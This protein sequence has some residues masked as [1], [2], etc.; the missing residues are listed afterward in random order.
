MT[1]PR[2]AGLPNGPVKAARAAL[3][4]A[5]KALSDDQA[6]ASA[7]ALVGI[8]FALVAIAEAIAPQSMGEAGGQES[9]NPS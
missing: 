2:I 5:E 8:G 9:A 1:D 4:D 6:R 7:I 3:F